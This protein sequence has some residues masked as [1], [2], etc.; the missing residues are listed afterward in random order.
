M[1]LSFGDIVT[2]IEG[3]ATSNHAVYI[4]IVRLCRD[5]VHSHILKSCHGLT[6]VKLFWTILHSDIAA[7]FSLQLSIRC[8][9]DKLTESLEK[10]NKTIFSPQN[11]FWVPIFVNVFAFLL[12]HLA[13]D[14]H[15]RPTTS[16]FQM[17]TSFS[18]RIHLN[19]QSIQPKIE[20]LEVE[21]QSYDILI[22]YWNMDHVTN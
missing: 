22:F 9:S 18:Q 13:G 12:L 21:M 17:S 20:I 8:T 2:V 16:H 6:V 4:A 7:A 15:P 10:K 5:R 11:S 1:S 14:V 3:R 19:T